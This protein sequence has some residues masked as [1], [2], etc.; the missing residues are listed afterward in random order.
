[1]QSAPQQ[2]QDPQLAAP[3]VLLGVSHPVPHSLWPPPP[4]P[5]AS[6]L[7]AYPPPIGSV[8][9][10]QLLSQAQSAAQ[11]SP[12]HAH[13]SAAT[14]LLCGHGVLQASGSGRVDVHLRHS[15]VSE[16][17]AYPC[18]PSTA[19]TRLSRMPMGVLPVTPER[20]GKPPKTA[21]EL[22][23]VLTHWL[24]NQ[25]ELQQ[26]GQRQ[27]Y[28]DYVSKTV[29]FA[30]DYG[31]PVSLAYHAEVVKA[32]L[33]QPFPLFDP[34]IHGPIYQPAYLSLIHGKHKLGATSRPFTRFGRGKANPAASESSTGK[35]RKQSSASNAE[36]D[37]SVPGHVGHTNADCRWQKLK[38]K[39]SNKKAKASSSSTP[40]TAAASTTASDSD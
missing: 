21:E 15:G 34:Y 27:A 40:S 7:A 2:A 17:D 32:L 8:G 20:T 22:H 39:Q 6:H 16:A 9:P 13:T 30:K 35:K 19:G 37:C 4:P 23:D 38:K 18:D 11:V 25:P 29:L 14:Q 24:R 12:P 5:P 31:L 1:M 28:E 10:V 3:S 33:R 26:D 36:A